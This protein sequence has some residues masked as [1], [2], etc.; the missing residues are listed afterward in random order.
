[1]DGG[2]NQFFLDLTTSP[3][4]V[5]VCVHDENFSIVD[6]A[7]SFESFIDGLSLDPDMI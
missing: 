5:K 4:A 7:P 6:I 2:G 3:P 1:M